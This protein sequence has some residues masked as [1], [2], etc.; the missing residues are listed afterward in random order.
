MH[1]QLANLFFA[2]FC[3]IIYSL[4]A[5]QNWKQTIKKQHTWLTDGYMYFGRIMDGWVDYIPVAL[6]L[7]PG[8]FFAQINTLPPYPSVRHPWIIIITDIHFAARPSRNLRRTPLKLGGSD[9]GLPRAAAHQET[10]KSVC[11]G[12][13]VGQQVSRRLYLKN[14]K[15]QKK[16]RKMGFFYNCFKKRQIHAWL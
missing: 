2:P 14:G 3:P 1:K 5:T 15:L 10:C 12:W 9:G 4:F 6:S 13:L 11:V 7:Y 16:T 8:D